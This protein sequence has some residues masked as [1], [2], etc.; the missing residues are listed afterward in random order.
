MSYL[1]GPIRVQ[2]LLDANA[3]A[4]ANGEVLTWDAGTSKWIPTAIG[5]GGQ[6][7]TASNQGVGGVGLYDAKVGVDLQFRNINAGSSKISVSLDAGNKEVDIDLGTVNLDHLADVVITSPSNGYVLTYDSGSGTWIDAAPTGGG[8]ASALD[9]LT[10]VTITSNTS[11]E[12]LKWN[13]SSWINNTLAEAG[14]AA[15]SHTHTLSDI[16]DAGSLAALNAIAALDDITDVTI[17]A[18][19][20]GEILKWSGT[21]WINNTLAEAGIAAASHTHATSDIT[22]GTFDNAR[23]SA[24][25]VTQHVAS[26]DHDATLNFVA[27]EHIDHSTVSISAGS[28]LTGGGTIAA[29]RTLSVD[30]NGLTA[31]AS[32]DGA[33]DYVMSYDASAGALKKVLMDNLPGGGGATSLDGLSDVVV[34]SV[35]TGDMLIYTGSQWDNKTI[36]DL[37]T[38]TAPNLKNDYLMT[39][40]ASASALKKIPIR[41]S[42]CFLNDISSPTATQGWEFFTHCIGQS[43]TSS[44]QWAEGTS[45]GEVN[46]DDDYGTD[47]VG[48]WRFRLN[49]NA[50]ARAEIYHDSQTTADL[51]LGKGTIIMEARLLIDV[52]S[53]ATDEYKI[54]FGLQDQRFSAT[55]THGIFFTYDRVTATTWDGKTR[56]SGTSTTVTGG[57]VV[58]DTWVTLRIVVA[59]DGGSAEF[60]INGSSIGTSS[61]NMPSTSTSLR[62]SLGIYKTAGTTATNFMYL[63]YIYIGH[64]YTTE[65]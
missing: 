30:I 20:A 17:T 55:L 41:A 6:A 10:D 1:R 5:G 37:S 36:N 46:E 2:D 14:I 19:S 28:G 32:P 60:F 49:A 63:D 35:A 12:I 47:G 62:G 53:N 57:T 52:L 4:P 64:F 65:F 16:T 51:Y 58:A 8:G 44:D 39:W 18:N 40:D 50:S 7:N 42:K 33:A 13:G 9:D 3:A 22:S 45:N 23:I 59:A 31:D 54:Y 48:Q 15:A 27:N 21:A 24:G 26:I 43:G 56:N 61:T 34:A 29:N 11:G 25:N 38:D